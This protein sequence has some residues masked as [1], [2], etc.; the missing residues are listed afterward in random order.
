MIIFNI[1]D[2]GS[3][4]AADLAISGS[5]M[6][7]PLEQ[8]WATAYMNSHPGIHISV[9]SA[10][11]GFGIANAANGTITAGASDVYL[12]HDLENRYPSLIS[13]PVTLED[14]QVL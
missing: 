8:V 5:S 9:A 11:S 6:L 1:P 14:A 10:G 7:F 2:V 13:I 3:A 12:M 4:S